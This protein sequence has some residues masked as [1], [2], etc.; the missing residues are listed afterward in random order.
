MSEVEGSLKKKEVGAAVGER[1]RVLEKEKGR[2]P[3]ALS[4]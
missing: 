2:K 3:C 1:K 4:S